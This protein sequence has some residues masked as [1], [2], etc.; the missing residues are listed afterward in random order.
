MLERVV[1][2]RGLPVRRDVPSRE[3]D[4]PGMLARIKQ[5]VEHDMPMDVVAEQGEVLAALELVPPDY[6]FV[7]GT[8][9]LIEGQIAGFYMPDDGTMY[10]ATDLSDAEAEE[11]LAHELVH[12]LQDQ[13]YNLD[14]LIAYVP[15]QSDRIGAAHSL[16]EGDAMSAMLDVVLGSA[17]NVSEEALRRLFSFS[18]SLTSVGWTTPRVLQESLTVPY[19]DGFALVQALR[20]RGGWKAVDAVWSAPPATTEQ[21]LHL[22]KLDAREPALAVPAPPVSALGEG[23][24]VVLDDEM[25]EQSLRIVLQEWTS[26]ERAARGAAGWGGDR[27][28]VA[29]R[30]MPGEKGRREV[31]VA[32]HIRFDTLADAS[33]A[34]AILVAH[35]GTACRQRPTLGPLVWKSRGLDIVFAAGPY[36]RRGQVSSKGSGSCAAASKW[37]DAILKGDPAAP[38]P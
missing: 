10:L 9:R 16:A 26:R 19:T 24:R 38:R 4:R 15:G 34:L 22:D 29:R 23:F 3:L 6:D 17:F 30:D 31:A 37:A 35:L 36:E 25:G 5:Q 28:V 27:Y 8:Y 21:L 2:A 14:K 1:G 20:R 7:A 12:A 32:W 11:T 13:S 33:E 18:T